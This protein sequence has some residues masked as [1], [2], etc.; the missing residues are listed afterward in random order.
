MCRGWGGV[1]LHLLPAPWLTT[2]HLQLET[3]HDRN[4]Y[5]WKLASSAHCG[6]Y[7]FISSE[8]LLKYILVAHH[9][10][11]STQAELLCAIIKW[12]ALIHTTF[13]ILWL[14]FPK[15]EVCFGF[16]EPQRVVEKNFAVFSLPKDVGTSV[17]TQG[18][19]HQNV[20]GSSLR[21]NPGLTAGHSALLSPPLRP[22]S[23][24]GSSGP[25]GDPRC[26]PALKFCLA[27]K[28]QRRGGEGK[29]ALVMPMGAKEKKTRSKTDL[30]KKEEMVTLS[31]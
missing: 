28:L 26:P 21:L 18:K 29:V 8:R 11:K 10:L 19:W 13:Y 20:H 14:H 23:P 27:S 30:S 22:F 15:A 3:G 6:F 4:V 31:L 9:C 1:F 17:A 5:T 2:S 16:T 12:P 25:L 7:F 24:G